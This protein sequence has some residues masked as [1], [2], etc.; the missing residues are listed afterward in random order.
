MNR[1]E[2]GNHNWAVDMLRSEKGIERFRQFYESQDPKVKA[3]AQ[4]V[5]DIGYPELKDEVLERIAA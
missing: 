1:A 2:M 5:L 4:R 3:R